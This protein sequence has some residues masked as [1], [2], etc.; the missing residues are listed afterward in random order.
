MPAEQSLVDALVRARRDGRQIKGLMPHWRLASRD[1]SIRTMLQVAQELR[2]PR[3]GWK[4]AATNDAMQRKLRTGEPV[5]GMTFSP[6]LSHA[7]AALAHGQ[8]LDPIVECEFAF[9]LGHSP[10]LASGRELA[11]ADLLGAIE[12]VHPCI[13]IAECR[14]SRHELPPPLFIQAD[15]FASGRYVLGP[16]IGH[17]QAL[18]ERGVNV[19][20]FRNGQLHSSGHS[21]DVMGHPLRPLVWLANA[22]RRFGQQLLPGDL[23]CTG[24]CNILCPARAGDG[25]AVHYDGLPVLELRTY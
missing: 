9:R 8:L 13:E 18:L 4:I 21:S 10:A 1:E 19:S 23:V 22:L 24:T 11:E 12:S 5:F 17:W 3:L 20:V 6:F 25:F 15:G 14:F 7:P 16:P 2:W